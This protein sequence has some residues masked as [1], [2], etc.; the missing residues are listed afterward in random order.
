MEQIKP[1]ALNLQP[2]CTDF[3]PYIQKM[4][5]IARQ[6]LMIHSSVTLLSDSDTHHHF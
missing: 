5:V 4:Y 1:P 2:V 6:G 3:Y